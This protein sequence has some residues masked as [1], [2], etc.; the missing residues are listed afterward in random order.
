MTISR[1]IVTDSPDATRNLAAGLAAGL[2]GGDVIALQGDLGSGKTC[3]AQGLAAALGIRVP[4]TSP[5]YTIINEYDA[6]PRFFHIDLY[7]LQNEDEACLAGVAECLAAGGIAVVEWAERASGLFP[8]TTIA[9]HFRVGEG[10]ERRITITIPA[11]HGF[12]PSTL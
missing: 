9:C 3:F 12:D 10:D 1:E 2:N 8:D 7:R 5:T 6:C 11:S 4:I